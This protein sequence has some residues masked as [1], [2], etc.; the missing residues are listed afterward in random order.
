MMR[1]NCDQNV[2]MEANEMI[3]SNEGKL[4]PHVEAEDIEK[5]VA[6]SSSPI[7]NANSKWS[8]YL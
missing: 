4:F 8:K 1:G 5:M 2:E 3:E 7:L 6:R